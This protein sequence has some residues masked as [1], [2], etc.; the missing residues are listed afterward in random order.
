MISD[1]ELENELR[2]NQDKGMTVYKET[3]VINP[4][5]EQNEFIDITAE[6]RIAVAALN[7]LEA[8]DDIYEGYDFVDDVSN[9]VLDKEMAFQARRLETDFFKKMKV[10]DKVPGHF[11]LERKSFQPD[12]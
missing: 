2:A 12:G 7:A 5:D 10:Y 4:G 8:M 6:M 3:E 1:L 9:Q 11:L